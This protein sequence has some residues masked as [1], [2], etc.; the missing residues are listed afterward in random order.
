MKSLVT[1]GMT[2]RTIWGRMTVNMVCLPFMPR[3]EAASYW[4]LGMDWMPA[5]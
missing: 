3:E 4:P 2:R 1:V 5:R